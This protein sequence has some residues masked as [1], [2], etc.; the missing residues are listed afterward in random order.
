MEGD[1]HDSATPQ[2]Q[3]PTALQLH[4]LS[5]LPPNE[6]ALSG[7]FVCREACDAFSEP[8]HCTASLSQPLPPHAAPWAQEA[9]QQHTNQLPFRDKFQLLSTA[10]LSGS[11]VNLEVAWALLEP[12]IFPE[13]LLVRDIPWRRP[14]SAEDPS[15]VLAKA[16]HPQLWGWLVRH[17]P[18]LLSPIH[19]LQEVAR[20]CSLPVLQA[21]WEQLQA[22]FT[23]T[24]S[25]NSSSGS[26]PFSGI[27]RPALDI[28]TL[29]AAAESRTPDAIAKM[30]WVMETG[31]EGC[32]P[33]SGIANIAASLGDRN[34]LSWA[35]DRGIQ[36]DLWVMYSALR[37]ADL[38]MAQWLVD[39]GLCDLPAPDRIASE[40]PDEPY[41]KTVLG[42]DALLKAAAA[43][44][45]GVAKFRWLQERGAPALGGA[46]LA[47]VPQLAQVAARPGHVEVMRYLL[48]LIPS[49][50]IQQVWSPVDQLDSPL[51][52]G[53]VP[54]A[55]CL[56]QAGVV[57]SGRD[58]Y[59]SA[60]HS[61]SV[62]TVRWLATK[63]GVSSAGMTLADI[64]EF[65]LHWPWGRKGLTEA[66]RL[67]VGAGC[68]AWDMGLVYN[69]A[70]RGDRELVQYLLQLRP[71]HVP[72]GELADAAAKGGCVA[73]MEW[74]AAEHPGC[75]TGSALAGKPL[76]NLVAYYGDRGMLEALRRLGVPW[77]VQDVVVREVKGGCCMPVVRW[78][79][80]AGAPVGSRQQL[81][82]A[83]GKQLQ[84]NKLNAEEAAWLRG[85]V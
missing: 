10:A 71:E 50:T 76:Y 25:S 79:V 27:W 38:A 31:G 47:L 26:S 28:H 4:V 44:E 17:C 48:S 12:S 45:D 54:M 55:E 22:L 77:V 29:H 42:W 18:R 63:A 53:K 81:H 37:A 41:G 65:M 49:S 60:G 19:F 7:R 32:Q 68:T 20:H 59:I 2:Q 30:Q 39:E 75:L 46:G 35:R 67:V 13:L 23:G 83:V 58:A 64:R 73:L 21:T 69:A 85:L 34:K 11:E 61:S 8:Q 72:G 80:E 78:L 36:C 9:G 43:S 6:R 14:P 33:C 16:G 51:V 15:Q 62:E 1:G 40:E 3:L 56:W 66:V 57:L 5:L 24:S 82:Q 52:S 74:L 84:A 70:K